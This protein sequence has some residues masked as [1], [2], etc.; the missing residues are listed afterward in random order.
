MPDPSQLLVDSKTAAKLLS[1]STRTLWAMQKSGELPVVR[2]HRSIRFDVKDLEAWI[3]SRKGLD[4]GAQE[5][6]N[7]NARD[8]NGRYQKRQT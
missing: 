6:S 2:R 3:D 8:G 5:Y 1:I 4:N 7:P